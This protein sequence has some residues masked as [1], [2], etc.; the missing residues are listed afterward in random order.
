MRAAIYQSA[1]A[2][3]TPAERAERLAKVAARTDAD[4]ILCPELFL[5]GYAVGDALGHHAEP[6]D[7]PSARRIAEIARQQRKAI[8]YGFP[9]R[10]NGAIFNAA[11]AFGPD[12]SLLAHH[13]KLAIPPGFELDY[14][15]PGSGL[16]LFTLGGLKLGLLI[17]Y[18][19]E[20][21]EAA[22][23]T[24]QAGAQAILVPTALGAQWPV[25][26]E[27]VIPARAFENGVYMLYANHAGTEGSVTF[28]GSSCIVGPDGRD[29]A[30]AA[31]EETTIAAKLDGNAV[32]L[33]QSRLPY[34]RDLAALRTRMT[35]IR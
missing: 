11:L 30:R 9:E 25:V 6:P 13:R 28:L 17:C 23:A 22:R 3:L 15:V 12:G 8:V 26:A 35:H 1:L 34:F 33:A 29:Q 14:F 7:G 20:F 21:P 2:G 32:A 27:K 5:T 10:E 24:A 19:A 18:D 4:L 16:T 31:T